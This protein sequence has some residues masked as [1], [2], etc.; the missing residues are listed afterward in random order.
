M[1]T[2]VQTSLQLACVCAQLTQTDFTN[3]LPSPTAICLYECVNS[4]WEIFGT[5][6]NAYFTSKQVDSHMLLHKT[7]CYTSHRCPKNTYV[8][9]NSKQKVLLICSWLI[10]PLV[11]VRGL[12][13]FSSAQYR[14]TLRCWQR[15]TRGTVEWMW[16][17]VIHSTACFDCPSDSSNW[18]VWKVPFILATWLLTLASFSFLSEKGIYFLREDWK[19]FERCMEHK[20]VLVLD[21]EN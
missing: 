19:A 13:G 6:P 21:H 8:A 7:P 16:S 1:R 14:E 5:T 18:P 20:T 15:Q 11:G 9:C 3:T 2:D 17:E 4:S 12:S 10:C